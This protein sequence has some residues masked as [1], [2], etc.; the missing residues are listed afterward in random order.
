MKTVIDTREL[1]KL[2]ADWNQQIEQYREQEKEVSETR[3]N[4]IRIHA[5]IGAI[6]CCIREL[7]SAAAL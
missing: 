6:I 4:K 3:E 5:R 1:E 2:I 7:K